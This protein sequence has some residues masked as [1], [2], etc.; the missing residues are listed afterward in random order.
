MF[1]P[2]WVKTNWSCQEFF[3]F[4]FLVHCFFPQCFDSVVCLNLIKALLVS[5]FQRNVSSIT[6]CLHDPALAY[7]QEKMG[8]WFS[9]ETNCSQQLNCSFGILALNLC[10]FFPLFFVSRFD[11]LKMRLKP[12]AKINVPLFAY[13]LGGEVVFNQKRWI[14]I[15]FFTC[16]VTRQLNKLV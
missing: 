13:R 4:Y 16:D 15:A 9:D 6:T 10:A 3:C 14:S 11:R 8:N 2:R 12:K 5:M 1:R 7:L